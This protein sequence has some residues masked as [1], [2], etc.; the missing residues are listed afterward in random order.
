M[1]EISS[2]FSRFSESFITIRLVPTNHHGTH[3]I[4]SLPFVCSQKPSQSGL[5]NFVINPHNRVEQKNE[6]CP[7]SLGDKKL[8]HSNNCATKIWLSQEYKSWGRG[9]CCL[10]EPHNRGC[11]AIN[12]VA[13]PLI[14]VTETQWDNRLIN[15]MVESLGYWQARV[16]FLKFFEQNVS[17]PPKDSNA[18]G[19]N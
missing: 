16:Y 17:K 7:Q 2:K 9:C 19:K 5:Q 3:A 11:L 15:Q 4:E 12:N 14:Q 8:S 13:E 10:N 18:S 6:H 1:V